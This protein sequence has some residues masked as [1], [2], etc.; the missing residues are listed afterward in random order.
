M[1]MKPLQALLFECSVVNKDLATNG[2]PKS[3][4][5]GGQRQACKLG[6]DST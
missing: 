6:R 5:A 1:I 3:R 2:S 4:Y